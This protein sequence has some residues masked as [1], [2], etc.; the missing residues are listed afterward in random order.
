MGKW[1]PEVVHGKWDG[2]DVTIKMTYDEAEMLISPGHIDDIQ[3]ENNHIHVI[4]EFI[5][6]DRNN[7]FPE[8]DILPVWVDKGDSSIE[9]GITEVESVFDLVDDLNTVDTDITEENGI[10]GI[11]SK[12]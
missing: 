1:N 10:S 3:P 9:G 12:L 11:I 5:A 7:V 6:H 8:L 4:D 2:E